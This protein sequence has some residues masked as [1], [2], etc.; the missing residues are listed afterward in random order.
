MEISNGGLACV[1]VCVAAICVTVS[2]IIVV[3][4]RMLE[5]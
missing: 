5:M 4:D 1:A 2:A 3:V